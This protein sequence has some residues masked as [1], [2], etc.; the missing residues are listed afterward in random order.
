MNKRAIIY[1]RV[2]TDDQRNNYSIPSQVAEIKKYI[3]AKGYAL[4]GNRFVDPETGQDA[5]SGTPAF[6]DDYSSRELSRPA[7]D[8]AYEYLELYGYDV[9]V[10]YSIDRLDRDPY[11]LR[12]HEYGFIKGGAI[13]EYVKGDYAETPDG[14]F[15]KTVVGA[16]AKLDNDWRTERFNRGKRQKA[17]RGLFVAGRAP[18]GYE[19]NRE[20][21]GGLAVVEK[22]AGIVKWIFES[23]VKDSLSLYG[24]VDAL[25][26]S[27]AKPQNGGIWQKSTIA[28][29]LV[30]STYAGT[31]YYNKYERNERKLELRDRAEWIEIKTTGILAPDLFEAAQE[32]IIQSREYRRKQANRF[33]MLAGMVLCETCERPYLSQTSV[34]GKHRRT[35]D[36]PIY[37]H[38]V[39]NGHCGNKSISARMLEP[40]IWE[41]VEALL[42][43]PASLRDG[44]IKALEHE[45]AANGRQLELREILYK[46]VGKLEQTQKN[47]TTAYTDPEVKMTRTEYLEQRAKVQA[48]LK[49]AASKLQEI[50]AQLSNLPSLEEYESLERFAEE[51]KE[52]LTGKEWQP[53]PAN[54]R[55]VLE[56]LHLRV[57][58]A[59]NGDGRITGWFGDPLGFSYKT[60]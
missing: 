20:A 52:R 45:R 12:T 43:D 6:V 41:K 56:L 1:A 10:V 9:V 11:K 7:L 28:H 57:Y 5:A 31:A 4:V 17:R 47:L 2:S 54:K 58:L 8:A 18:Y 60:Y 14:Q 37:R 32:K 23:Y 13:V 51:I 27:K 36:A 3:E 53:T 25:N 49:N 26:Q 38:R 55:R 50:E 22:D 42:L 21:P 33:Y 29:M 39:R 44:Y 48:D 16:A 30:N 19:I 46:A 24:I 15:M 59:Y 35:N 34:G 40:I